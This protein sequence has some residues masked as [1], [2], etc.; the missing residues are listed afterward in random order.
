M[1]RIFATLAIL[2]E[3]YAYELLAPHLSLELAR[4]VRAPHFALSRERFLNSSVN[5]LN[6]KGE[7]PSSGY[8]QSTS[9]SSPQSVAAEEDSDQSPHEQASSITVGATRSPVIK[10]ASATSLLNGDEDSSDENFVKLAENIAV[11]DLS[12]ESGEEHV[13]PTPLRG[14]KRTQ[15]PSM[16]TP[17]RKRRRWVRRAKASDDEYLSDG[18]NKS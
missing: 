1:T 6:G 10:S 17:A 18:S 5:S 2:L 7:A 4:K 11:N 12:S 13:A 16:R 8:P 15:S 14:L 3:E 9:S